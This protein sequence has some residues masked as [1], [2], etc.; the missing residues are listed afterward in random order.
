MSKSLGKNRYWDLAY[1]AA[2]V[3][4]KLEDIKRGCETLTNVYGGNSD[5]ELDLDEMLI[6]GAR[7]LSSLIIYA[8][9]TDDEFGQKSSEE[10]KNDKNN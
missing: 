6:K 5:P 10:T 8:K 3:I 9:E 1:E 4:S 2:V 7:A